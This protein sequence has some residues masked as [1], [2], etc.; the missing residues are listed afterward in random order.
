[1]EPSQPVQP[2]APPPPPPPPIQNPL[3]S[4]SMASPFRHNTLRKFIL[5]GFIL[6]FLF[7]LLSVI[8][9]SITVYTK[10]KLPLLSS[11]R[12]DLTL[13][14]YKIPLIPKNPEQI[15]ITAVDKNTRLKTYTPDFSLTA[16]LKTADVELG[17]IDLQVKGPVDITDEKSIAFSMDGKAAINFGG[18]SYEVD[19]KVIE[20]NKI[21]YAKLDKLPAEVINLGT[22]MGVASQTVTP[23]EEIKQNFEELFKNWI[24]YELKSLPTKA[25]EELEKNIESTSITNK[26]RE[27]SENFLLKSSILPEVKKLKDEKIDGVDTYHLLLNP[28]KEKVKQLIL[29]YIN[30]HKDLQKKEYQEA[31]DALASSFEQLHLEVWV[32]KDDAIV[33]KTSLQTQMDLGFLQKMM[34][35]SYNPPIKTISAQ[36]R[37]VQYTPPP[38]YF[39]LGD[40]GKAKLAFSTVVV[41]TN[42]NKPVTITPP[43]KTVTVEEYMKLFQ[44]SFLTKAAREQKSKQALQTQD[45][46]DISKELTMYYVENNHYPTSLTELLGKYIQQGSPVTQRL[47]TYSYRRGNNPNKFVVYTPVMGKYDSSYSTP[48][49]GF[50]SSYSYPHQLTTYEFTEINQ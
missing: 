35:P 39:G 1:M 30:Q 22:Y 32:G 17:S 16:Q 43:N 41:L 12:R 45:M 48:Y 24:K 5:T 18:H 21:I 27:E 4:S 29:E 37:T 23:Q 34:H 44:D 38:D 10:T 25:R 14:F 6:F 50:T 36:T 9:M 46:N 20:K 49:F 28:S 40:L 15:L 42:V 7:I 8:A 33:R 31:T 19:G 13:L 2:T 3:S 47:G 26:I 11:H